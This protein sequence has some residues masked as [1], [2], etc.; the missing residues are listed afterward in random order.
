MEKDYK[1]SS[2]DKDKWV[3][4][5]QTEATMEEGQKVN[6]SKNR[7]SYPEGTSPGLG[8]DYSK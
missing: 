1:S 6:Y 2:K 3:C 5:I 7:G 4:P 8:K